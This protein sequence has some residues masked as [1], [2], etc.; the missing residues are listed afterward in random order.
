ML[1]T[2]LL[3]SPAVLA[4]AVSVW[5]AVAPCAYRGI[6]TT[7]TSDG[8]THT[9]ETCASLIETS[10]AGVLGV[11]AV[12]PLLAAAGGAAS[13]ARRRGIAWAVAMVLLALCI[14]AGF[15]IGMLYLPVAL[16]LVAV[17]AVDPRLRRVTAV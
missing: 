17:L 10:G 6:T 8:V 1:R 15:S 3:A 5:L 13:Y 2:L 14:V 12:P 16:V 7:A 9:T 11:L 4:A